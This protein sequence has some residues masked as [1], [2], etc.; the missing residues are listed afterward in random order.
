MH[1]R[2]HTHKERCCCITKDAHLPSLLIHSNVAEKASKSLRCF[3]Q[4]WMHTQNVC[5][6]LTLL[7][8]VS[9]LFSEVAFITYVHARCY[10]LRYMF[11]CYDGWSHKI[12][13]EHLHMSPI[14]SLDIWVAFQ[15]SWQHGHYL[16]MRK[17][18]LFRRSPA[19][20]DTRQKL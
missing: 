18:L 3:S 13:W 2:T 12:T 6:F 7:P 20:V 8:S 16:E 9:T 5:S 10:V 17:F 15:C 1:T 14:L 11:T 4:C 19:W